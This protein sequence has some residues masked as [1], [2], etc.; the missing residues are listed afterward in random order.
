[1]SLWDSIFGKKEKKHEPEYKASKQL[2]ERE[3]MKII[4]EHFP[5]GKKTRSKYDNMFKPR[6]K[7]NLTDRDLVDIYSNPYV[8]DVD[9]F[10]AQETNK[11]MKCLYCHKSP[12]ICDK[13]KRSS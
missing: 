13:K 5:D 7:G 4:H 12:C 3:P 6:I 8:M 9:P 10:G 11:P 2:P 1:M